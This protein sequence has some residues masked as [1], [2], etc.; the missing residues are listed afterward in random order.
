M[1]AAPSSTQ[2]R[3]ELLRTE[4]ADLAFDLERRGRHDAADVVMVLD[5]RLREIA[6]AEL[7]PSTRSP[8][9]LSLSS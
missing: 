5:A 6:E 9:G 4:L 1:P 7:E 3:L 2:S 8:T